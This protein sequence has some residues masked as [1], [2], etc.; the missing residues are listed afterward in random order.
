GINLAGALNLL[1]AAAVFPVGRGTVEQLQALVAGSPAYFQVR[2][3]GT[4][5]GFLDA[6]YADALG[7]PID[8]VLRQLLINQLAARIV[9]R[10]Q[11]ALRVFTSAEYYTG[12]V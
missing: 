3:G 1:N 4:N 6:L 12:L 8:P 10:T 7:H 2:G 11:V 9:T 5:G